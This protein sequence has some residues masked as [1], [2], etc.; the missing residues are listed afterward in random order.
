MIRRH[1]GLADELATW[2][3]AD[4]RF[5][6]ATPP[7]L[8]L[9]CVRRSDG[10]AATD[11]LITTANASGRA[12]FTRTVL[13]GRSVLRVCVGGA[14]TERRHVADAWALLQSLA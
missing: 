1:I 2:V 3:N 14:R 5:D 13:D 11:E 4:D 9:V 8:N 12:L 10:D 7:S 6:F